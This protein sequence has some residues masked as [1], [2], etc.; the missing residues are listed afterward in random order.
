MANDVYS[1]DED[2]EADAMDQDLDGIPSDPEYVD[3]DQDQDL[4]TTDDEEASGVPREWRGMSTD[5]ESMPRSSASREPSSSHYRTR[6]STRTR[7][8]R[9]GGIPLA[10]VAPGAGSS[11]PQLRTLPS[12]DETPTRPRTRNV[13]HRRR[14]QP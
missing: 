2:M 7:S 5:V 8:Q 9:E 3:V 12:T 4:G 1:D 13:G 10:P 6:T 14:W 11:E